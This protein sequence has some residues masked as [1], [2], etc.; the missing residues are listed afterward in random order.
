VSIIIEAGAVVLFVAF[1]LSVKKEINKNKKPNEKIDLVNAS[2]LAIYFNITA[3]EVNHIFEEL[4]WAIKENKW[5]IATELGI[6][7]GGVQKYNVK[8]KQKY[9]LWKNSIKA[10]YEFIEKVRLLKEKKEIEKKEKQSIVQEHELYQTKKL[11]EKEKKE[12]GDM[13]ETYVANFFREQ[14]YY[15][16]EHGKEKGVKDSSIDLLVKKERCIY[17]V[18]CKHWESWKIDHKEVK[19]TRTD[20]RDYI[21]NNSEIKFIIKDYK[22]KILYVTSKYCLTAGAKK[23]IEENENILEYQVVKIKN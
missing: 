1:V 10:N 6:S 4:K 8:N 17:F 15:V 21:Q 5:W 3:Q 2:T 12:K 20:I 9:I 14:G 13:Y 19:A 7:K 22:T 11:S 18:Q 16:W 23:Y